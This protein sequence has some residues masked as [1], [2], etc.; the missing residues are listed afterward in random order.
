MTKGSLT[1][2]QRRALEIIEQLDFARIE[3]LTIRDG[4][5]CYEK[6]PRI[7]EKIKLDSDSEHC[8]APSNPDFVLSKD[9]VRLFEQFRRLRDCVVDIEVQHFRLVLERLPEDLTR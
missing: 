2:G 7:V 3:G 4:E 1:P 9:F 5:P 6:P 8:P